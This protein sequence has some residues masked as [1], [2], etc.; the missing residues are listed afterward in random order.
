M[1]RNERFIYGFV[2]LVMLSAII[3]LSICLVISKNEESILIEKNQSCLKKSLSP[4]KT[5]T[6][7]DVTLESVLSCPPCST[8]LTSCP[9][10]TTVL[11]SCPK[12]PETTT[13]QANPQKYKSRSFYL[14]EFSSHLNL[15]LK[16]KILFK[17]QSII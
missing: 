17:F 12:C 6:S 4:P 11:T 1:L 9:P 16:I 3:A 10:S 2:F 8:S 7:N 13:T 15:V 14:I 5:F